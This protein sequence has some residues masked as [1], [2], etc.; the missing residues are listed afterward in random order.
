MAAVTTVERATADTSL[1]PCM[2]NVRQKGL[3]D[4]RASPEGVS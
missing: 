1:R 3:D 4:L 2:V